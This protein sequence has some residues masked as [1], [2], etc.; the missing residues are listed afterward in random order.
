VH[1]TVIDDP[2]ISNDLFSLDDGEGLVPYSDDDDSEE[3]DEIPEPAGYQVQVWKPAK[4]NVAMVTFD[5]VKALSDHTG[6]S[7]SINDHW[8]DVRLY[9]G[10]LSDALSGLNAMEAILVSLPS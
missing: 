10:D 1:G 8:N 7:F 4:G 2:I 9:G 3:D 6:S 5:V